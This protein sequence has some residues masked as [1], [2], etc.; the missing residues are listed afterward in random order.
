M[1]LNPYIWGADSVKGAAKVARL[2]LSGANKDVAQAE[3]IT[4]ESDKRWN[5]KK[6]KKNL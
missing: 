4:G 1:G 3:Q 5:K 2:H 6:G